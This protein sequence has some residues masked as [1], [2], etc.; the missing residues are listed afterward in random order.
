MQ[1]EN[2][3]EIAMYLEERTVNEHC[4]ISKDEIIYFVNDGKLYAIPWSLYYIE[5]LDSEGF[6]RAKVPIRY[7]LFYPNFDK[8]KWNK[9]VHDVNELEKKRA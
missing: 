7:V 6:K 8:K 2:L 4:Y 5:L 9:L 3:I 1:I